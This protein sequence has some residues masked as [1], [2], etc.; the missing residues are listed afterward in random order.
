MTDNKEVKIAIIVGVIMITI[1]LL[2]FIFH[3]SSVSTNTVDIK[4]YKLYDIEGK[5]DEHEYRSCSVTTEQLLT[6][7]KEYKK[8]KSL[9]SENKTIG[10]SIN[11]NY[12]IMS[13]EDFIA[14][15]AKDNNYVYRGDIGAIFD[16]NS[17][18]YEY[19]KEI[20]G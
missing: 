18:L 2:I 3:K 19:V 13:G 8:I 9:K 15:D 20:C 14:F 11:G 1:C 6:I 5:K 7:N 12:K 4:V 10:K 16:Y 17:S